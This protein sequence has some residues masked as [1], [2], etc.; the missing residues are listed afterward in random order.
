[1]WQDWLLAAQF[2]HKQVTPEWYLSFR[3]PVPLH[4][5][6]DLMLGFRLSK[7]NRLTQDRGRAPSLRSG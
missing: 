1:M 7:L 6:K 2:L 3:A 4:E 5:V